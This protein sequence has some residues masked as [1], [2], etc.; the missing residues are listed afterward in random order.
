MDVA[1]FTARVLPFAIA[2]SF[3]PGPN[4][5]MLASTGGQFGFRKAIPQLLGVVV[6][7][8]I[9]LAC[10]ALGIASLIA[11]VPALYLAMKIASLVYMAYLAWRIATASETEPGPADARPMGFLSAA[12][13]QWINPK[14]WIT[15]LT[16]AASYTS[17]KL[18]P[19]TQIAPLNVV[20]VV[21]GLASCSTWV[22]FGQVLRRFLTSPSR[23]K[24]FNWTMAG[25]LVTSII[26]VL[27]E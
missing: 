25:L 12:A 2:M 21:V 13:V 15:T 3:T 5:L 9:I 24:A 20:F 22:I 23:R 16:A 11:A 26:P 10:V 14:A 1:G 27:F 7:F 8:A 6:G 4:N 19:L 18:D 17:P